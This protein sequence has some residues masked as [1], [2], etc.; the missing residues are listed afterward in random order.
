MTNRPLHPPRARSARTNAVQAALIA[1][2]HGGFAQPG[3]R[4]LSTRAVAQRFAVSYQTA[5]RRLASGWRRDG[6]SAA[7]PRAPAR[8]AEG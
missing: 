2:L 1:R 5:H 7:R 8:P 3:G 4:F 6:C